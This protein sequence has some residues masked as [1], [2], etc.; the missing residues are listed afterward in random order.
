MA[1]RATQSDTVPS[2][3][4]FALLGRK[5][6]NASDWGTIRCEARLV[7]VQNPAATYNPSGMLTTASQWPSACDAVT[8]INDH[9]I[10]ERTEGAGGSHVRVATVNFARSRRLQVTPKS[11]V[12]AANCHAPACG[13]VCARDLLDNTN[14][15]RC[16]DFLATQ[17]PW[18]I[19]AE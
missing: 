17:G 12:L 8:T 5:K 7:P 3:E 2:V 6:Q 19:Q 9:S 10:S 13:T 16:I 14:E 4:D 1:T 18:D 15:C 11:A